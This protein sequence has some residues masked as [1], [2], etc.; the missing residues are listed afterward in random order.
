MKHKLATFALRSAHRGIS[1]HFLALILGA[2]TTTSALAT[3]EVHPGVLPLYGPWPTTDQTV[4]AWDETPGI[5]ISG[6]NGFTWSGS[7]PDRIS[8]V[9]MSVSLTWTAPSGTAY[10]QYFD[11]VNIITC[12]RPPLYPQSWS[13]LGAWRGARE[14]GEWHVT[15]TVTEH[16][17]LYY[18]PYTAFDIPNAVAE[19]FTVVPEP[20]TCLAGALLLLP[21]G[22]SAV[23][24]LRRRQRE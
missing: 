8:P 1:A 2:L 19:S 17:G 9:S 13:D 11:V 5:F 16:G 18:S 4:F 24:F 12:A 14:P 21:F 22:L 15:G 23:R 6:F 10:Q 3:I 7:S 20:S